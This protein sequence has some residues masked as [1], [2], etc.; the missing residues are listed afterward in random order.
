MFI[1]MSDHFP[2]AATRSR[3]ASP[4]TCEGCMQSPIQAKGEP[5]VRLPP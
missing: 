1:G 5:L 2:Y 3:T 4:I